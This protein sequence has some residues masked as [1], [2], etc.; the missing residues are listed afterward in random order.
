M[1]SQKNLLGSFTEMI[2]FYLYYQ[3]IPAIKCRAC[4]E[5][6]KLYNLKIP[7]EERL[8]RKQHIPNMSYYEKVRIIFNYWCSIQLN[9][10]P[11]SIWSSNIERCRN[12]AILSWR[13]L[14]YLCQ[15]VMWW[16]R[17]RHLELASS[18][19]SSYTYVWGFACSWLSFRPVIK[20]FSK[21]VLAKIL[22]SCEASR[23]F[24]GFMCTL[25]MKLNPGLGDWDIRLL[26]YRLPPRR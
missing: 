2:L 7:S 15:N 9:R 20:S 5:C 21:R 1:T 4:G 24:H 6:W 23:A 14:S 18:A 12:M 10:R 11:L 16:R 13:S 25:D 19:V 3:I 26:I 17:R 22:D 8:K